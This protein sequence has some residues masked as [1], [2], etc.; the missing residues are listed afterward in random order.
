MFWPLIP[1]AG[2]VFVALA[3]AAKAKQEAPA[4]AST[5]PKSPTGT[6]PLTPNQIIGLPPDVAKS[7]SDAMASNDPAFIR[8]TAERLADKYTL[9]AA[10]LLDL[11]TRLE[12]TPQPQGGSSGTW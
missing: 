2:I 3:A 11:A 9:Q 10:N 7:I 8:A 1:I 5:Q 4:K 12:G 6:L